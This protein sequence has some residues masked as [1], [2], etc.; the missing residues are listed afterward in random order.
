[1]CCRTTLLTLPSKVTL[2]FPDNINNL[3]QNLRPNSRHLKEVR[4]LKV[5]SGTER[6]E[7]G[8]W[9]WEFPPRS[10]MR[11]AGVQVGS[12]SAF[13]PSPMS[14]ALTRHDLESETASVNA[15][16]SQRLSTTHRNA[17]DVHAQ[18]QRRTQ[19]CAPLSAS[20]WWEGLSA[21]AVILRQFCVV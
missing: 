5:L 4:W 10:C 17:A 13:S 11:H 7:S 9:S 3:H 15:L 18:V 1:M 19:V 20:A 8:C 16:L 21:M 6:R 2:F 14:T 12:C